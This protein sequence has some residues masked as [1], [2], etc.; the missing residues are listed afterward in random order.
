MQT[1]N[2]F[3]IEDYMDNPL[4][5]YEV[6]YRIEDKHYRVLRTV[7]GSGS[8]SS[9]DRSYSEPYEHKGTAIFV[10]ETMAQYESDTNNLSWE[11]QSPLL[12][13]RQ[14]ALHKA[15]GIQPKGILSKIKALFS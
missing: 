9:P 7:Q 8:F 6:V 5:S 13:E 2:I 11:E 12:D 4:V 3:Y 15:F 10:A 14:L 1:T